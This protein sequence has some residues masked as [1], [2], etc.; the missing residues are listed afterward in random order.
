MCMYA[1]ITTKTVPLSTVGLH[2]SNNVI[3]MHIPFSF[4]LGGGDYDFNC[5][6][7]MS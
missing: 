3:F 7:F 5:A 1:S 2:G 6:F 4:F